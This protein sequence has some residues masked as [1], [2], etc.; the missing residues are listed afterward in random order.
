MIDRLN[1]IASILKAKLEISSC[2][3]LKFSY[4]KKAFISAKPETC[5]IM[6]LSCWGKP[7]NFGAFIYSLTDEEVKISIRNEYFPPPCNRCPNISVLDS[8]TGLTKKLKF[9]QNEE[10]SSIV[11]F[12]N[13]YSRYST[14]YTIRKLA[15]RHPEWE[16]LL[17]IFLICSGL[18][19]N[20]RAN[21]SSQ[22]RISFFEEYFGIDTV[23]RQNYIVV[24][25]EE[26]KKRKNYA[27]VRHGIIQHVGNFNCQK[28]ENDI[29][30]FLHK[31]TNQLNAKTVK[32]ATKRLSH[33]DE[34]EK[35]L[36]KIND[37]YWEIVDLYP[38]LSST[39][40][41]IKYKY[42]DKGTEKFQTC[43]V[44]CNSK[45]YKKY[46]N[47]VKSLFESINRYSEVKKIEGEII[48]R[49]SIHREKNCTSCRKV[50]ED[51]EDQYVTTSIEPKISYCQDCQLFCVEKANPALT[52]LY[53]ITP[54]SLNL[55]EILIDSYKNSGMNRLSLTLDGYNCSLCKKLFSLIMGGFFYRCAHCIEFISCPK[56][57]NKLDQPNDESIELFIKEKGHLKSHV[58]KIAYKGF[59]L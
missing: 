8:Q 16:G 26:A 48:K 33:Y 29:K 15:E 55:D 59:K 51:D 12:C 46:E 32:T 30:A 54:E 31:Q 38:S 21:A 25:E 36:Q 19:G 22:S 39:N 3:F 23:S 18:S 42:S 4:S 47:L 35:T 11:I 5:E 57:Y 20:Y 56:C 1:S 40:I 41:C 53:K 49:T 52:V 27:I 44:E 58:F 28:I 13:G 24:L 34:Y 7:K 2:I 14:F 9:P 43:K 10:I 17:K 6:H 37:K 50:L 45:I